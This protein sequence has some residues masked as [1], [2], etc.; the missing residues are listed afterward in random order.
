MPETVSLDEA[1]QVDQNTSVVAD[2]ERPQPRF[3]ILVGSNH[4]NVCIFHVLFKG[5]VLFTYG[6]GRY[7]FGAYIMTFIFSVIFA[8]CDFWTVK[9]ITGRLLVGLRWWNDVGDD[10]GSK[11]MFESLDDEST[12]S[13]TDS[14]IF[15]GVLYVWP[16]VWVVFFILN[17]FAFDWNWVILILMVL[18]FASTNVVGYW[19]CSKDQKR[20]VADWAKQTATVH[21][22][23]SKFVA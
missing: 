19:K 14:Y 18:I 21:K 1:K 6:F 9:N 2:L 23:V 15:W 5:L 20:R 8:T 16:L 3:K 22:I 12:L 7:L 4:P 11:W 10:G 17:L 13:A